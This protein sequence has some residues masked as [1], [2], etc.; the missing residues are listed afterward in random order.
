MMGDIAN[1]GTWT[2]QTGYITGGLTNRINARYEPA[3]ISQLGMA[4]PSRCLS[5]IIPS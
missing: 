5:R 1:E 4:L 2:A 3:D